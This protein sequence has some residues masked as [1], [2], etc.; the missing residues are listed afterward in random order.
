MKLKVSSSHLEFLLKNYADVNRF[1]LYENSAVLYYTENPKYKV[2]LYQA[3]QMFNTMRKIK[4]IEIKNERIYLRFKKSKPRK[5]LLLKI[6]VKTSV[7]LNFTKCLH[8]VSRF[9]PIKY[10]TIK[11]NVIHVRY[12]KT[13][14]NFIACH[15]FANVGTISFDN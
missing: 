4:K 8:S 9:G 5:D 2:P 11:D 1:R 6:H 12:Q 14:S 3:Y 15:K 10:F 7:G 13:I